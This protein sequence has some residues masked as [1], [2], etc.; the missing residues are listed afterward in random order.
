[1]TDV[2]SLW[3]TAHV[4]SAAIL[5]GTGLGIAFFAWFGYRSAIR[6]GDIDGLKIVLRLT[7]IADMCFTAPAVVFQLVSGLILMHID[8]WSLYSPWSITALGLFFLV[9][10]LWLPVVVIQIK[11]S[12]EVQKMTAIKQLS[13]SFHRQFIVWFIL[14]VP[15]FLSWVFS[16]F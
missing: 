12:R 13:Q 6:T 9:G 7:V 11:M 16:F 15:A 14:G 8:G 1:M 3:K 10:M 2:Y 5:F 4:I